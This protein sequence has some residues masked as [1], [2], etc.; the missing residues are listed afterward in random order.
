MGLL[1][2]QVGRRMGIHCSVNIPPKI[3]NQELVKDMPQEFA[4]M[5]QVGSINVS[6]WLQL[7]IGSSQ[8]TV[9]EFDGV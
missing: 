9:S 7:L 1:K 3:N 6:Q 8:Y 5:L 2:I 4:S